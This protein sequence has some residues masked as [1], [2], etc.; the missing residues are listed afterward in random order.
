MLIQMFSAKALSPRQLTWSLTNDGVLVK[1]LVNQWHSTLPAPVGWR[2]AFLLMDGLAIVGV[3]TWGRPVARLEESEYTLEHTRMALSNEAPR[4]SGS[5]FLAQNR[6]WIRENMP[7]IGRLIAYINL[8][9]HTGIV[10][11]ADNW[12]TVYQKRN[13]DSW[14]NRPG[15]IGSEANYRA[16]FEREP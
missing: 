1:T 6:K 13:S 14:T 16:K 9:H 5:W 2:I 7:E 12:R 8:D 15:R 10:Y 3:S 4:N 11:R